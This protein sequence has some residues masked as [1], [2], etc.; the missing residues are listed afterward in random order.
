[1]Q[2]LYFYDH[3]QNTILAF[4][5]NKILIF[6]LIVAKIWFAAFLITLS[7]SLFN[8]TKTNFF[9]FKNFNYGDKIR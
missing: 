6:M 5:A 1:M 4:I 2:S 8:I 9:F 7:I 3:I